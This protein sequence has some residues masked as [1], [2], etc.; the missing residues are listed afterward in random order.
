M[1]MYA[2]DI[3][4]CGHFTKN[5]SHVFVTSYT[6]MSVAVLSPYKD[7]SQK[8]YSKRAHMY[9]TNCSL[10]THAYRL[11]CRQNH[12][13]SIC[14]N[15]ACIKICTSVDGLP[16][17]KQSSSMDPA[18]KQHFHCDFAAAYLSQTAA[19]AVF[20]NLCASSRVG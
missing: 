1:Y 20:I 3:L 5:V 14:P 9:M 7:T 4:E 11:H 6:E 13:A 19:L 16:E 17:T 8:S 10:T 2:L 15:K 18:N 12:F